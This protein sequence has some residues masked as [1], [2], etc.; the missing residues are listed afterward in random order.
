M[1][2]LCEYRTASMYRKMLRVFLACLATVVVY[3]GMKRLD[4]SLLS[5]EP[6]Q[7]QW[8]ISGSLDAKSLYYTLKVPGSMFCVPPCL[9]VYE[10]VLLNE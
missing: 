6:M 5:S 4:N 2:F 1:R 10:N 8:C 9:L 3:D 7:T